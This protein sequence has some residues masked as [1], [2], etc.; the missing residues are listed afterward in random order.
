M[1]LP[2]AARLAQAFRGRCGT[3]SRGTA[4]ARHRQATVGGCRGARVPAGAGPICGCPLGSQPNIALTRQPQLA[5]KNSPA[6]VG[7][8]TRTTPPASARSSPG[9]TRQR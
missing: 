7:R 6:S 2:A 5:K 4:V 1:T 8:R 3:G 9:K